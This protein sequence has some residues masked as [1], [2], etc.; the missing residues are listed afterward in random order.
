MPVKLF[1]S[2][3]ADSPKVLKNVGGGSIYRPLGYQEFDTNFR[4]IYPVGSVYMNADNN[5]DPNILLGFG[6]WERITPGHTLLGLNYPATGVSTDL[7]L[8]I[9]SA[10]IQDN[11]VRVELTDALD[12]VLAERGRLN[13]TDPQYIAVKPTKRN[14]GVNTGS[15]IVVHGIKGYSGA[16]PNGR[17]R[18]S[19]ASSSATQTQIGE[20]TTPDQI[21]QPPT[22]KDIFFYTLSSTDGSGTNFQY[23]VTGTALNP[24]SDDAYV[25]LY[26]ET[27]YPAGTPFDSNVHNSPENDQVNIYSTDVPGHTH[28]AAGIVSSNVRMGNIGHNYT[29]SKKKKKWYGKSKKST[30]Y[31]RSLFSRTGRLPV[32]DTAAESAYPSWTKIQNSKTSSPSGFGVDLGTSYGTVVTKSSHN[33]M[34]PYV[35][36]HMWKRIA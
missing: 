22:G 29:K 9:K 33:N 7:S 24:K 17:Q 30:T 19:K 11:V 16:N 4:D 6:Q 15:Y 28:K 12:E 32:S 13:P 10:S 2:P 36:V 27:A 3:N 14:F 5:T 26:D 20:A 25:T 8:K 18:I 35:A 21:N 1:D 31:H 23:D 34:Q